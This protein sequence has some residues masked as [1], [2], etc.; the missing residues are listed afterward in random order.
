MVRLDFEDFA[1]RFR[2]DE[3]EE[4][5]FLARIDDDFEADDVVDGWCGDA[6]EVDAIAEILNDSAFGA[7]EFVDHFGFAR[8]ELAACDAELFGTHVGVVFGAFFDGAKDHVDDASCGFFGESSCAFDA[9]GADE[10]MFGAAA[11]EVEFGM[12]GRLDIVEFAVG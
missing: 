3:V 2:F 11:C 12:D 1:A 8:E 7:F 4:T 9:L 6:R 10:S 5:R